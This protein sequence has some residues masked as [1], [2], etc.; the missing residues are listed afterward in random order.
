MQTCKMNQEGECRRMGEQDERKLSD[1]RTLSSRVD[2]ITPRTTQPVV[3]YVSLHRVAVVPNYQ[4]Y[5]FF[6]AT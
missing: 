2:S 6:I 3:D 5:C 1:G 4:Y